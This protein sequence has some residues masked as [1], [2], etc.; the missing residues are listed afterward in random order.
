MANGIYTNAEL[1]DSLI[2]DLNELVKDQISG[3]YIGACTMI[4]H[5]AQ[6]LGSLRKTIDNDLRNRDEIIKTLKE[7]L[8][9]CGREVK[10]ITPEEL[11]KKDGAENGKN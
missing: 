11:I 8:R 7:E 6:K 9:R 5:M 2:I 1:I 4:H 3:Q 10:D